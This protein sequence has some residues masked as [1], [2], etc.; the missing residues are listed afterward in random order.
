MNRTLAP[1]VCTPLAL[2]LLAAP[3]GA[4]VTSISEPGQILESPPAAAGLPDSAEAS[5]VRAFNERQRRP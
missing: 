2:S 3:V 5:V 1:F 4:D